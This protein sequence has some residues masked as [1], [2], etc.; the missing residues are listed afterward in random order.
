MT[1]APLSDH[2]AVIGTGAW[3]LT[4]AMLLARNGVPTTLW[5]RTADEAAVLRTTRHHPKR[6]TDVRLPDELRVTDDLA[7]AVAPAAVVLVVVPSQT[8]RANA[9]RLAPHISR[10]AIVVSASKGIEIET[11]RRMTEVLAA[12][13]PMIP[14]ERIGT[15]SGPNLAREIADGLPATTVVAAPE[16][17]VAVQV[18]RLLMS[19]TFRVYTHTDV[20]GV[21][22][23]GV[24]KNIV[25]LGAGLGDGLGLGD[26]AKA[27]FMTRG[28]AEIARLGVVAGAQAL[29]FAGLAG[30]GDVVA[31]CSSRLSRNRRTGEQLARGVPLATI[32][33]QLGGVAEAVPT[34]RAA[35]ILARRLGVEMPITELMY[36]V[37]FEGKDPRAASVE[38]MARDPKHEL[39]GLGTG[40]SRR[41]SRAPHP[42]APSPPCGEGESDTRHSR[43]SGN[44]L[45]FR[46]GV[47]GRC[48]HP[49][50]N[51]PL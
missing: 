19:A 6:L 1:T 17:A 8:M 11:S 45:P 49:H 26:N 10:E 27:A 25:A 28:L 24:L 30:V 29:T 14:V 37:L 2:A 40:R 47:G 51:L 15:L 39:E 13:L 22:L 23:G 31:T 42:P 35:R 16:E 21:E 5:A 34:T 48:A 43:A 33:A 3:G 38:L 32:Q 20:I 4:L 36:A 7:A 46:E 44:P 9:E 50:E 41:G 18:Q 12:A